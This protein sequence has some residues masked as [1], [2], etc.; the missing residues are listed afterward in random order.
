MML[1]P[2]NLALAGGLALAAPLL[3]ARLAK[4]RYRAIATARLGL[5]SAWLPPPSRGG[6]WLHALSV[7]EVRSTLPLIKALSQRFPERS[8]A[9]S[10]ATAQ[11]LA[12]ARQELGEGRGISLFVRPLDLYWN[13][14]RLLNRLQPALFCLVEGDIWPGWNWGL[15]RR[16]VP[17]LLVNGRVSPR[18]FRGYCR[19]GPLARGL[20]NGFSRILVQT[21]VDQERLLKVGVGAGRLAVGGNLKFD[22]APAL[23][24]AE[25]RQALAAELGLAGRRVLVAG[26]THPGEEEACLRAFQSLAASR[27]G[28]ALVLAPR[29]VERGRELSRL[30]S[31]LGLS[32]ACLSQGAPPAGT[33]VV[34]LDL[35]GRLASAYAPAQAA[36]VGGSL[37]PVGGHN[38]L[39]PAAQGVPVL[40]GPR[41]H[42][43]LEM[44][45]GLEE[46]GGGLRLTGAEDLATAWG[47]LLDHPPEAWAMG[48]AGMEFCRAHRGAVQRAV[49][50]IAQLLER[51]PA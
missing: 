3:A 8:L 2:Y 19:A 29:Q 14:E 23:L 12:V 4:G 21:G 43:F 25:T 26:S 10:V 1:L 7:G 18:T 48:Q 40:F 49:A 20:L 28:L 16:G 30:A 44:A 11:G 35:L 24:D 50:E 15:T 27:P 6:I 45:R 47:R 31:G 37:V 9:L 34:V 13:V 17:S 51:G 36:F 41:T 42:N 33:Q 38:L 39:E 46:C 32:A 5:G 22:S